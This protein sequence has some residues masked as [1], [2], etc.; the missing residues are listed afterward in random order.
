MVGFLL[1]LPFQTVPEV[2][3][4]ERAK[5][6]MLTRNKQSVVYMIGRVP[7]SPIKLVY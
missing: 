2:V 6:E 5:Y 3:E 4:T 7:H 1:K